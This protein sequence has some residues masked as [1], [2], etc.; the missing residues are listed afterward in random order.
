[1]ASKRFSL[2]G[3]TLKEVQALA[4][5]AGMTEAELVTKLVEV[6]LGRIELRL[7]Q[8]IIDERKAHG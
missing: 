3:S 2:S 1:M 8:R 6:G 4:E 5:A 7:N